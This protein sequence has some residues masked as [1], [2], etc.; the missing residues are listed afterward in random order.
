MFGLELLLNA[1][2][3][4]LDFWGGGGDSRLRG[5]LSRIWIFYFLAGT[6]QL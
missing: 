5:W 3:G 4:R 1:E 6:G 2:E